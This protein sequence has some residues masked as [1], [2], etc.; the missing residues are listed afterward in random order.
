MLYEA[1]IGGKKRRPPDRPSYDKFSVTT[2]PCLF[3]CLPAFNFSGDASDSS[4]RALPLPLTRPHSC[5]PQGC[6]L[7][8]CENYSRYRKFYRILHSTHFNILCNLLT[9]GAS[10]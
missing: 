9:V 1:R 10:S 2:L 8:P 6:S 3:H 5:A 4:I 7:H